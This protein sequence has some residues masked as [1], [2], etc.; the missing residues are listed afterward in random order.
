VTDHPLK[1]S[2]MVPHKNEA[3][4]TNLEKPI[5]SPKIP[6]KS[7]E[8]KIQYNTIFKPPLTKQSNY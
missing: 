4:L 1:I 7:T 6:T 5:V 3:Q 8:E 2:E